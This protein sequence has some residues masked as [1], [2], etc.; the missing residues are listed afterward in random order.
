MEA[1]HERNFLYAP[2]GVE[3]PIPGAIPSSRETGGIYPA[4]AFAGQFGRISPL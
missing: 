1:R 4:G 3:K 2:Q